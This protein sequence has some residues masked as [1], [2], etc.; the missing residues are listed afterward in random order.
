MAQVVEL[1]PSKDKALSSNPM[2]RN[3]QTKPLRRSGKR[4]LHF[5]IAEN[6]LRE[7]KKKKKAAIPKQ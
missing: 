2:P 7:K 3:K 4:D 6:S 1:L 5:C